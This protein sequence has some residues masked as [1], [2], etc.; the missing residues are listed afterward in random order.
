M[1]HACP[2]QCSVNSHLTNIPQVDVAGDVSQQDQVGYTG[3]NIGP[4][5]TDVIKAT[6]VLV[7]NDLVMVLPCGQSHV[8]KKQLVSPHAQVLLAQLS[9]P[10]QEVLPNPPV[11]NLL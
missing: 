4:Q 5:P 10:Q 7:L 9:G 2:Q 8:T 11:T 6:K 1:H 3:G